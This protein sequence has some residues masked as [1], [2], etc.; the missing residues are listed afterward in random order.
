MGRS[1][2][3]VSQEVVSTDLGLCQC[4]MGLRG[5]VP[6]HLSTGWWRQFI[7]MLSQVS[8]SSRQ[9]P[10]AVHILTH[11][12]SLP[13]LLSTS[14]F[15]SLLQWLCL[16]LFLARTLRCLWTSGH[17]PS[18]WQHWSHPWWQDL[19][20]S[21]QRSK[22]ALANQWNPWEFGL[23]C[24]S[25]PCLGIVESTR[26][27]GDAHLGRI[28]SRASRGNRDTCGP[29]KPLSKGGPGV[30]ADSGA[31]VGNMSLK[32]PTYLRFCY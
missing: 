32:I 3:H 20:R 29:V 4:V 31:W 24:P 25:S 30:Q 22:K 28:S 1:S 21:T 12:L 15:W 8:V 14:I 26:S 17:S 10:R 27:W 9:P 7:R 23:S 5:D 19:W 18:E 16:A 6:W 11:A 13:P 2:S